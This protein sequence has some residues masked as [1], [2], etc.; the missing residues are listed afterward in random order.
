MIDSRNGII[1]LAIGDALGVPVEFYHRDLLIENPVV[2]MQGYG[3][4]YVPKGSWSDDTSM[5]LATV[6]S[7]A[8][9]GRVEVMDIA[10]N[11]LKWV[12]KAEFTA[13][14]EVFDIGKATLKALMRYEK[15]EE[16]AE[17]AGGDSEYDN[18][19]GSLMRILPIAYYCNSHKLSDKEI[20]AKVITVS[21]IT[22]KHEISIMACYIYVIFAIELIKGNSINEAY[23]K[24]KKLDY[25][26]F[27]NDCI[28]RYSRI[29]KNDIFKYSL[30]D[31]KST[32]YVVDTLE[33]TLWVLF[34]TENYNQAVI[35]AINLGDDTDTVGACVGGLAGIKYG[36]ESFNL[37]WKNELLK[38]DYIT[39]LCME[40]NK[41]LNW[42]D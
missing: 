39:E 20:L 30:D 2:T 8:R 12:N 7:I 11:F 26:Y 34:N 33:A 10:D 41:V 25:S 29:L 23:T 15:R 18:G 6:E 27:S 42:K 37:E 24:I 31:I 32:A 38:Y 19:N 3:S 13:N 17:E 9:I 21:S 16:T 36:I 14:E 5:T 28:N 22:H 4:H 40:F 35:G 1:G